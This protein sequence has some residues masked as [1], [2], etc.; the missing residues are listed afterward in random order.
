MKFRR[1]LVTYSFVLV[2]ISFILSTVISMYSLHRMSVE[3]QRDVNI[4]MAAR[5]HDTITSQMTK[6]IMVAKTMANESSS[7]IFWSIR[8]T[9]T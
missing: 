9:V 4:L 3:N 6:P 7:W 5:I 2:F 1:K 8:R